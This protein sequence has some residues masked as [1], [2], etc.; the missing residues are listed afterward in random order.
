MLDC[1]SGMCGYYVTNFVCVF[2]Q[3]NITVL[4]LDNGSGKLDA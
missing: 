4:H 1:E 2:P 3:Q